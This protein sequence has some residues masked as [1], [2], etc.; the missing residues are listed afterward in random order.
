MKPAIAWG[1]EQQFEIRY[2]D[3]KTVMLHGT[4]FQLLPSGSMFNAK[5]IIHGLVGFVIETSG[6]KS[7]LLKNEPPTVFMFNQSEDEV[8]PYFDI[9]ADLFKVEKAAQI[10]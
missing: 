9:I 6:T 1:T 8:K 7:R 2:D 3:H 4:E 5:D 10:G